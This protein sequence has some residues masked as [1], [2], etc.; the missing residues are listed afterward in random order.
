MIN[1]RTLRR[2]LIIIALA[3]L[4]L[5]LA[6]AFT[7]RNGLARWIWAAGT[8]PVVAGLA[9]SI[10]RD[11]LA[12]RMGVDAVAFV[13]MA[14]ALA[15][16]QTLAGVVVAI[17][18]A[19]GSVLEDFAVG[20]AERD[21]KS[22]VDRAPRVA[23]RKTEGSFED[24]P[25]DLVVVGDALLVRAGEVVPVDGQI[26]SPSASLDESAVTGEP[27]PVTRRAGEAARSGAINAGETFEMRASATAGESTYAG[28]IKMVT[29]AQTAKAPFIR[30]AD[31][32]ALLLLP[33]T[34]LVAGA[35]W[36]LSGDPVRGLAVLVAATPCPL[37]LAAPVAFIAGA[38]KLQIPQNVRETMGSGLGGVVDARKVCVGS[39]QLVYGGGRLE[40][41]AARALRRASWRSALSVFV[42]IDGR[43][44]GALLLAD[45][46]RRET[47]RAVRALRSAGVARIVMVTGD[48]ADAAETIGAALDLDAVLADRVS[49]DKVEAVALEQRLNP[50]LMVGDGINDAPA[51]AA[52]DVGIAMGARGAS[53]SSEAADV[54]ILVNQ[55]DRVSDAVVIARRTRAIAMQSIVVGMA[56]S[57]LAMGAAAFGWLTP[58]AGALTQEAIDVAVILNALRALSPGGAR[59]RASMPVA[60]AQDLRE[61]HERLEASLDRLR[62]IADALDDADAKTAVEYVA[63][64]NRIVAKD[65]VEHELADENSVYPRLSSILSDGYGL[66][67]MSRAHREILHMARLLARLADGLSPNDA[68]RYLIRDGQRIIESIESLVRIHS[69]QEEDIYESAGTELISERRWLGASNSKALR[70]RGAA[71]GPS[72]EGARNSGLGWRMAAAALAVLAFGGGWLTWSLHRGTAAHYVT[73]QLERG[74]VVR[75]VTASGVVSPTATAPVGARVSGVIQALYC[76]ANIKVKM[77]Q[78]CAKIDPRPYQFVVEKNMADL[79]AAG[80]RLEKHQADLAQAKASIEGQEALAKRRAVSR[81]AIDKS[82]KAF[83]RAQSQTKRDEATVAE[84]QAALHAAETNLG[85]TDIVSPIDGTVVSRNVDV[86]QRVAADS[87]TPPLFVIAADLTLTHIDA[88]ISERDIGEVKRGDK[89][90]IS[91]ASFPNH[92][93]AGEVTQ[94]RHSPQTHEDVATYDVVISAPNPDLLLEADMTATIRIVI[95]RRDDVLRAPNQA[96]YYSPR[97]LTIPSGGASLRAPPDGRSQLWILRD[98]GPTAITVQLGLDDGAY[99]EIVKGDLQPGDELIIGESGGVLEKPAA[100]LPLLLEGKPRS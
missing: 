1:E 89:A 7:G 75:T 39:H 62:Q 58:V 83:E 60:A 79:A 50:T 48:R 76:D 80:A 15:L 37:I 97:N 12:G 87:E 96:L 73:Q 30:M 72:S 100:R 71:P 67:A 95:N 31:R 38:A 28:I 3:G 40:E 44:A 24:V 4:A 41:W 8:I 52:A 33:V 49:A 92:L 70:G 78:L 20:R 94:I 55:L 6:A 93:F 26:T 54:V 16:G 82:R 56:L 57:G 25:I 10:A 51:L 14:A 86:G 2:A 91:I 21:L 27:I 11:F 35:A 77:G 61:D 47:P 85:Y 98:G 53:A 9:I 17:M 90:S 74:S 88:I 59:R 5:G 18:Y 42:S 13:S 99:T 66:F 43:A 36:A 84:L 45:E 46:L 34:L 19:G 29:A 22:L 23:H 69:A 65:I 64:A 63:E 81:K 32:F 68:D